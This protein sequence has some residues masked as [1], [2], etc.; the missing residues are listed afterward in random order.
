MNFLPPSGVRFRAFC[1][2]MQLI[3]LLPAG[4]QSSAPSTSRRSVGKP[5]AVVQAIGVIVGKD[6]PALEIIT[7]GPL[8]PAIQKLENPMRLVIDLPDSTVVMKKKYVDYSSLE[9]AAIRV[10]QFQN[11]PPITRVVVDLLKPMNYTWDASG[12][13]L[14]VRL[15]SAGESAAEPPTVVALSHDGPSVVPVSTGSSGSV[16]LA[17][18]RLTTGSSVTAGAEAAVLNLGRGGQVRVC[19]GTTL[20]VTTSPNGRD[21]M[22][23]MG[24]GSLEA[25]YNL[26]SSADSI[27]TPDFRILLAGPGEFH[28]AVSA[29]SRGNTCVRALPGNT[30][31]AIVSELIGDGT[32]QVKP[33][34]QVVFRSGRLTAVDSTMPEACGCPAR[35][36]SLLLASEPPNPKLPEKSIPESM[37]LSRPGEEPKPAAPKSGDGAETTSP[38]QVAVT[39][40]GPETA[41]L[42]ASTPND[43]HVQI[44][45]PFVFR[46]SDPPPTGSP[47]AAPISETAHLPVTS[48]APQPL[49][50]TVVLAPPAGPTPPKP[51]RGFFGK[52]KGLF[53][54]VFG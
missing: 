22:L 28:Y 19:P 30:A 14:M 51:H 34:E 47:L 41:P 33:A 10:N 52:V 39:A 54:A 18:H 1:L 42:P 15:H 7:T 17:G 12:N 2:A 23:G 9:V 20:S 16:V 5:P 27:L 29:D 45:A 38:A 8:T 37:Q 13:R 3:C 44:E 4:A 35:N 46:A 49:P 36:N 50:T 31:S 21:L 6:G 53:S 32:Y 25:H 24:T 11:S 40:A 48:S 26:Q 43:V